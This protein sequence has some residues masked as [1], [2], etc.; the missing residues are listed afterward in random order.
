[1]PES[2]PRC[3]CCKAHPWISAQRAGA[4]RRARGVSAR[5]QICQSCPVSWAA[6]Q[7]ATWMGMRCRTLVCPWWLKTVGVFW[8]CLETSP[9]PCYG[10]RGPSRS[11]RRAPVRRT[12]HFYVPIDNRYLEPTALQGRSRPPQLSPTAPPS[13]R[14]LSRTA[15]SSPHCAARSAHLFCTHPPPRVICKQTCYLRTQKFRRHTFRDTWENG[16]RLVART[17]YASWYVGCPSSIRLVAFLMRREELTMYRAGR[18][19]L[20][21]F[22]SLLVPSPSLSISLLLPLPRAT[23]AHRASRS[24]LSQPAANHLPPWRGNPRRR[25]CGSWCSAW[26]A[27]LPSKIRA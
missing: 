16:C 20:R 19:S 7:T 24:S 17:D 3:C 11:G 1:M 10:Q 13:R 6:T 26:T 22:H 9:S 8:S 18:P 12:S 23:P 21:P 5:R 25:R 27:P 14:P 4:V 15:A 2:S